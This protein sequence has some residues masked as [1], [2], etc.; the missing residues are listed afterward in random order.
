[1]TKNNLY[2]L[3][4]YLSLDITFLFITYYFSLTKIL[5]LYDR[6]LLYL[7]IRCKYLPKYFNPYC[8][9]VM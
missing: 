1:M 8:I 6:Y 2:F 3:I 4:Q 9:V 7:L 5:I